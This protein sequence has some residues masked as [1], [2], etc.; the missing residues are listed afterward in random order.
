VA[1]VPNPTDLQPKTPKQLSWWSFI[2]SNVNYI[3]SSSRFGTS[4]AARWMVRGQATL[5]CSTPLPQ[6]TK[7]G[8]F[9]PTVSVSNRLLN[10]SSPRPCW[11]MAPFFHTRLVLGSEYFPV[12]WGYLAVWKVKTGGSGSVSCNPDPSWHQLAGTDTR[13][14]PWKKCF[15]TSKIGIMKIFF[16]KTG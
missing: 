1:C 15:V 4:P 2:I 13:I 7:L 3:L 8:S 10:Q 14:G 11:Y 5:F 16:L 12:L 6:L 9:A